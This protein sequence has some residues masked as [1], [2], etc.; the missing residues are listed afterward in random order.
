MKLTGKPSWMLRR[1]RFLITVTA[2]PSILAL[3]YHPGIHLAFPDKSQTCRVE[4]DNAE[5][6]RLAPS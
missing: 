2:A 3:L 6:R 5:L 4:G 1:K